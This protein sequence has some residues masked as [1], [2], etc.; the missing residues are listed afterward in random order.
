MRASLHAVPPANL[1]FLEGI[2]GLEPGDDFVRCRQNRDGES[3]SMRCLAAP[4]YADDTYSFTAM[5]MREAYDGLVTVVGM[6]RVGY[7]SLLREVVAGRPD[8]GEI[9]SAFSDAL[10]QRWH[11]QES[12]RYERPGADEAIGEMIRRFHGYR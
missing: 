1:R 8:G 11:D 6:A 4:A 12:G 9:L 10:W 7:R 2:P 3:M 5:D